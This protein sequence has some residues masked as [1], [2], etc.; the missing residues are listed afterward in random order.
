MTALF[1]HGCDVLTPQARLS[2][3][4]VLVADGLIRAV[5]PAGARPAATHVALPAEAL[6]A[7]GY[8][9]VQVNGGGGVLFNDTPTEAAALAMAAAHRRL[10]TLA[11]MPTLITSPAAPMRAAASA[12]APAVAAQAGVL[13]IHF[14]GPFLSPARPGV[15]RRDLIRAPDPADLR[16]LTDLAAS[17]EGRV[18]LTLAPE[19]VPHATQTQLAEAG[20]ILSAG[21]SEASF[22]AVQLPLRG[23]THIFNAMPP[24]ASRAPGLATAAMLGDFF[25]GLIL[26]G[27]HVHPAMARLLLAAKSASRIMLVSD[28]MSVTGTPAQEFELLG[29]RILRR[30]GRLETEDG[31]LAGAD[32]CLAQAVRNAVTLLGVAPADAIAMASAVPADFLG[33]AHARG[34]IAPGLRADLLLLSPGL[35]VLGSW[36]GGVWQDE[37]GVLAA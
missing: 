25:A 14:E 12:M 36:L 17:G 13:G 21:H 7:P 26:D 30:N 15:H 5:L 27:I 31:V 28:A 32:L 20:V 9:D 8:I 19:E 34:R 22:E 35:D 10:G 33:L 24:P 18:M 29:R 3:H 11:I 23:I 1:L 6:L 4:G 2:G 37:T 16:L